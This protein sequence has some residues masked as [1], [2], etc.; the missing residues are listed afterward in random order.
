MNCQSVNNKADAI[1]DYIVENNVCIA[2]LTESWLTG[3]EQDNVIKSQ[4]VPAGYRMQHV[5]RAGSR[6]G[7]V[8][9]IWKEQYAMK[10]EPPIE[11]SSFESM[12]MLATIGSRA[13]RIVV[14][15]R[16]PPSTKNKIQKSLF[17]KEFADLMEQAATWPGQLVILGDFNIHWDHDTDTEKKELHDLL[18]SFGI[19]QHVEGP[20]HTKGHTLDLVMSRAD[21]D[22]V[23]SCTISDFISDHNAILIKLNTSRLHP[24]RK[25]I[26]CR[27]LRSINIP[28]LAS[29][30]SSSSLVTSLPDGVDDAVQAYNNILARLLDKHA[31]EKKL[32]VVERPSQPWITEEIKA[33]KRVKR[34]SE[35]LWRKSRSE[36]HRQEYRLHCDAVKKVIKKAKSQYFLTKIEQCEGDQK[37]LFNIVDSLL[38]RGKSTELPHSASPIDLAEAFNDFFITKIAKIRTDLQN[39]ESTTSTLSFDLQSA[40]APSTSKL[41]QF[42]M[43][44][45]EDIEKMLK[46]SSK[47]SC[48]LDPIPTTILRQL[49]CLTP[50]ITNIVNL[51]LSAG[52]F[53]STLKSAIVKPLLK[54][55]TLDPEIFKNFRP[56]SNLSFLSKVIEKA[57]VTQLL[58]HMEENHLLEMMQSAYRKAHSTETALLRVQNDILKAVDGKKKVV[59]L[60]L[61]DLSAAFDTVDHAILLSF[62]KSY[63]GLSGPVLRMLESYLQGR[64]QCISINNILSTLSELIFG[65][66]QGSVLGPMIFCTYTIPLGAILRKH[67]M[68]YH[69]YADDT[70]LYCA[71]EMDSCEDTMASIESCIND[72]R[73]WMICNKLKINDDKTEFLVI[74]SSRSSF[75]FDKQLTIGNS[76]ITP[77]SSCRNLGVMFDKHAKMDSQINNIC[78]S[79]HFH[80]RNIG[81]IR[82]VLNEPAT[83][84]LVHSLVT[85]RLDYCNSLL[86]GLP[87]TQLD[88]LQRIQNIACRIVCLVPKKAHITRHLKDQHWLPIKQRIIFKV[89][90]LTY[91]AYNGSA[92]GYMCDLIS[93]KEQTQW[94]LRRDNKLELKAPVTRLKTYGDRCFEFAA[95]KEWNALPLHVKKSETLE[96]FKVKLKTFLFKQFYG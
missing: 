16:V 91:R 53:P 4:S 29:D 1:N 10:L 23:S 94:S 36:N 33:M 25:T 27:K 15:Y 47:A 14:L 55:A 67:N 3:N 48:Q 52:Y 12:V 21:E 13:F 72:I 38:G 51:S 86:Y 41:S 58:K 43:C 77:C 17:I 30:I 44:S 64:T 26:T 39:L 78:R 89:L 2:A 20:T 74:S 63:V 85:S 79:T 95:A 92:P 9:M 42:S 37:K 65:V 59:F 11:A 70:Q 82:H 40:L 57:I 54:K 73:S 18:E 7:G 34:K 71:S 90:L 19:N 22:T 46:T 24:L 93:R 49:P 83:A 80:L 31:P 68:Q 62:L 56:V 6:G 88:R 76:K 69:M 50:V 75:N 66:P 28:A 5:P 96:S 45:V 87:D 84:Q 60:V 8:A 35:L 32:S 81:T 61:L